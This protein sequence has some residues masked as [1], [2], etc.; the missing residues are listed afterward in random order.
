MDVNISTKK[1][2]KYLDE[3]KDEFK[4]LAE[5]TCWKN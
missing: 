3:H 5:K 1:I 4:V 2:E